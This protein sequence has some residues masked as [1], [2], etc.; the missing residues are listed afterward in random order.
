MEGQ[1]KE[2]GLVP[3]CFH[4]SLSNFLAILTYTYQDETINIL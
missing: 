1:V 3:F 4:L 2:I